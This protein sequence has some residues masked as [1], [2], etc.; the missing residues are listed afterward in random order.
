[1]L[2]QFLFLLNLLRVLTACPD[3]SLIL[4][5]RK[6]NR[7]VVLHNSLHF[8]IFGIS[9]LLGFQRSLYFPGT[10]PTPRQLPKLCPGVPPSNR[11][12]EM[13]R[14]IEGGRIF[15]ST[16]LTRMGLYYHQS[17]QNGIANFRDLGDQKIQVGR[18]LKRED[19]FTSVKLTNVSIHFR[20]TQLKGFI[21]KMHKKKVS[22]LGQQKLYLPK[23][24]CLYLATG[25]TSTI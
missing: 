10:K 3:F 2:S 25:Q 9:L 24:D 18:D 13:C 7:I 21:S 15:T 12:M 6:I 17:Y 19:F 4:V 23:G 20:M 22:Q 11:I 1:M 5:P 8:I 16:G 14:W